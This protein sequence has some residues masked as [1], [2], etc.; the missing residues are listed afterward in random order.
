MYTTPP[1]SCTGIKF[2]LANVK[3]IKF[4][5]PPSKLNILDMLFP[6]ITVFSVFSPIIVIVLFIM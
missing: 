5:L 1:D 6:L 2:A 3:F 4:K